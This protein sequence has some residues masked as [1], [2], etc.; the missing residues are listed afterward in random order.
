MFTI[1]TYCLTGIF[2]TGPSILVSTSIFRKHGYVWVSAKG[3]MQPNQCTGLFF[4][5]FVVGGI[6]F[7]ENVQ[8]KSVKAGTA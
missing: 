8:S 6:A 1:S 5:R 2:T 4:G 7:V 3:T